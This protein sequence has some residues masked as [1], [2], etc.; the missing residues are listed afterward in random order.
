MHQSPKYAPLP[1][2]EGKSTCRV[3]VREG[4]RGALDLGWPLVVCPLQQPVGRVILCVYPLAQ[5]SLPALI[6][7]DD[8][9]AQVV[10]LAK[11]EAGGGGGVIE[12]NPKICI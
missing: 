8:L 9:D 7:S 3:E 12:I 2:F 6:T 10:L 4:V 11:E 5:S 1:L